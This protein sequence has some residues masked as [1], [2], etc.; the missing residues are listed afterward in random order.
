M[1]AFEYSLESY[2]MDSMFTKMYGF[3]NLSDQSLSVSDSE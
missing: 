3:L 1:T 2:A